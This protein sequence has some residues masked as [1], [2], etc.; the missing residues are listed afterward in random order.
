MRPD[1]ERMAAHPLIY[2]VDTWPW[3]ERLGRQG[4][5]PMHLA[6]VPGAAWD[7]LA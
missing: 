4:G 5:R 3:L 1:G 7:G 6:T 2:E